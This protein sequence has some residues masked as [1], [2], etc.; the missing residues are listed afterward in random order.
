MIHYSQTEDGIGVITLDNP[1]APLNILSTSY[2]KQFDELL[3]EL[4][5]KQD[6]RGLIVTSGKP[7]NF[8][9]GADIKDFLK[10]ETAED[11]ANTSRAGQ[12]IFGKVAKLGCPS[13][14]A[15]NGLCLGGGFEFTLNFSSRIITDHPKSALGFPEVNIGLLPGASGSQ[16]LP[17]LMGPQ[18]ALDIMLTG[19]KIYPYKAK[20]MG[21]VDEIVSPGA[22]QA[23][24]LERVRGLADGSIV[25][26]K[27]KKPLLGRLLDGPLKGVVYWVARKQVLKKSQGNYPAP[28]K[29]I[30]VVRKGLR[31]SLKDGLEIE[32]LGFGALTATA[33]H[34]NLTH[35]F[36]AGSTKVEVDAQPKA[37]HQIAVLGGGLMGSGIATVALNRGMTV[38]QKDVNLEALGNARRYLYKYFDNQVKRRITSRR[39]VELLMTRYSTTTNYSGFGL[40]DVVVEA[41][42]E[43]LDLKRRIVHDLE[44]RLGPDTVIATNTSSI[45]IEAIAEGALHPER[46]I[47][48]HF[49][50]PVEKMPLVELITSRYTDASTL[51]T[52]MALGKALGKK[53]IVVKDSP[54]FFVNRILTPYLNETFKLLEDGMPV[55]LLDRY[56]LKLGFPIGPCIL[57]D[58]VGLDVAG[59]VAGVMKGFIGQ[60]LEMTDHNQRFMDDERLGRKNGRG[61]YQYK[62][63]KRGAVDADVY[64]L[65]DTPKR[66]KLGYDEVRDRL[67]GGILNEAAYA[68]AEGLIGNASLGDTGAIYGFG[69]PPYLGGPYWTIDQMGHAVMVKKME[70][71]AAR[72]GSRFA[73]APD[74]VSRADENRKYYPA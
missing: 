45:P 6:L 32:A 5:A 42:Y 24:A 50:S 72:H 27:L 66:R 15:I 28:L 11:G 25:K 74:L 17:R 12:T 51:A 3:D 71:L 53:V 21:L 70:Q 20:K 73:P 34:H 52:T 46:I 10:F 38:R 36:F 48:M 55:D 40:S 47:G 14:A 41:V 69:Y 35:V 65:L 18:M 60:R 4:A 2:I 37:V 8:I 1:E 64:A 68:Y 63:G 26:R 59:K 67:L 19:K 7:D 61:F 22:L 16:L 44:E 23:A 13:V 33:E 30:E 49:F 39:D 62:G 29:I 9:V 31:R 58:E 56:A 54:G 43:D 57:A